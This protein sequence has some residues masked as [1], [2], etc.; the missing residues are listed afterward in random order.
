MKMNQAVDAFIELAPS[1]IKDKLV[2]FKKYYTA[3]K[4]VNLKTLSYLQTQ[5]RD[6][7]GYAGNK[8]EIRQ[9]LIKMTLDVS[10]KI[11]A[12]ADQTEDTVLLFENKFSK[13]QLVLS[14]ALSCYIS[15]NGLY[16]RASELLPSLQNYGL[17]QE[18]L[19]EFSILLAKFHL[20]LPKPKIAR[21]SV[22]IATANLKRGLKETDR[23]LKKIDNLVNTMLIR[24]PE[25]H[26]NFFEAR[27]LIKPTY[28]QLSARGS[29]T[30]DN[31]EPLS[32]VKM[33][34]SE[35]DIERKIPKSG[36]FKLFQIPPG[37]YRITFQ[38]PGYQTLTITLSVIEGTRLELNIIMHKL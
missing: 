7:T 33:S 3:F 6:S 8:N 5:Q 18:I 20:A 11:T 17:T 31:G 13:R 37:E 34:C 9:Q 2:N 16:K 15:C 23:I 29:V 4:L 21:D 22:K 12:P 35:L 19:S 25:F 1:K 26:K 28:K 38:K 32:F 14:S 10:F 30:A 36:T 24:E 27:K